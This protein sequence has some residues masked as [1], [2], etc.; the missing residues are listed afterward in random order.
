MSVLRRVGVFGL[1]LLIQ[2]ALLEAGLRMYQAGEGSSTFQSLFMSDPAVG[3]RLAPGASVRYATVEFASEIRINAQGVRDDESIGPKPPNERRIVVLGDSLV[4]S[5]QVSLAE[6]FCKDLERRLNARGG[7][8]R[9]RVINAG[10]QGYGPVQEWFFF[11][12]VVAA[13]EPDV[14]LIVTFAGNDII[15]AADAEASFGSGRPIE[16]E[17][18]AVRGLRRLVRASVVLQSVRL[19]WDQ[20]RGR[21]TAGTPERPLASYL[22]DPPPEVPAGLDVTRRALG[23]IADRAASLGARTAVALMPARFQ[24]DDA[25]YGRL[26]EIVRQSGGTLDRNSASERLATALAPLGLPMIDLQPVLAD[27]PDR[28]GLFFQRNVHLTPR[29]HQVVAGALFEFLDRSG[30]V[31]P[32]EAAR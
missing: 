18:P 28:I 13:F 30:L 3:H 27:Q 16:E 20:L 10:V 5:V 22:A 32:A 21:L 23:R 19:R 29:G 15:E 25:D 8:S 31:P 14:V 1:V 11:D 24:T 17:Q 9:W 4:F 26:A 12:T 2:S 7:P 6:T